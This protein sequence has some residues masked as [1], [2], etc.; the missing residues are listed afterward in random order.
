MPAMMPVIAGVLVGVAIG[1]ISKTRPTKE[2]EPELFKEEGWEGSKDISDWEPFRVVGRSMIEYVAKY[3]REI[4]SRPVRAR[5]EPGYLRKRLTQSEFPSQGEKWSDIMA[6]VESHIMPGI[7]HWQ[8]P[9]FFAYYP[10]NSSPPGVLSDILAS[11]FNVIGFSW[12]A[13]PAATEL[14]II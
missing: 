7:T 13:S 3:Y 5:V 2:E 1:R 12:E 11:M 9:R 8:H 10:G 4:E 14:E 6:D